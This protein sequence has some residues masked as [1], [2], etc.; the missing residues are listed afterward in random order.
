MALP[1]ITPHDLHIVQ[2]SPKLRKILHHRVAAA[3]RRAYAPVLAADRGVLGEANRNFR[4][5]ASS[6]RGATQT[7]ENALTHALAGIPT[8]GL[9]G[10]YKRQVQNEISS[11]IADNASALPFLLSDARENRTKALSEGRQE[12][13]QDR[14]AMLQS[15]AEDF[16]QLLKEER[17][18]GSQRL[19]EA[20]DRA[21]SKRES[22]AEE[23]GSGL[24]FDA[25]NL[26][27]ARLELKNALAEWSKNPIVKV[28]LPDGT[29]EEKHLQQIN[30]LKTPEDW[31]QFAKGLTANSSG[32][33]I[34]ELNHVIQQLLQNKDQK[35]HEGRLPQPG[36][37][38]PGRGPF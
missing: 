22:K 21:R 10:G 26:A 2:L 20:A 7:V 31:A 16:N 19:K 3:N 32:F 8:S 29:E 24:H 18:A 27:N 23:S 30:P 6:A 13:N 9:K 38:G 17:G 15:T 11:R 28:K 33:D 1:V 35:M 12:L 37:P 36:I 4:T 34:A 25:Q 14:A 5:E